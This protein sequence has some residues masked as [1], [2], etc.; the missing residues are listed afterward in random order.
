[1]Q[2]GVLNR[3][4]A[5]RFPEAESGYNHALTLDIEPFDT[6]L[7]YRSRS[8]GSSWFQSS[9][10]MVDGRVWTTKALPAHD[11]RYA[12]FTGQ[13]RPLTLG[14]VVRSTSVVTPNYY[15]DSANVDR[16]R[17]LKSA[18]REAR[19]SLTGFEYQYTEGAMA[20]P[21]PLDRPGRTILTSE[22]GTT[23]SRTK[24]VVMDGTGKLR[25]LTPEELEA[26]QGFPRGHTDHPEASPAQRGFLM[27]NALVTGLV[28][29][30]G[31]ALHEAHVRS[32]SESGA[33]VRPPH[34]GVEAKNDPVTSVAAA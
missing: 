31:E 11:I 24:H 26:L 13:D 23:P 6:Q 7:R 10:V 19:T 1:M 12:D 16:W 4:F 8:D 32:M 2:A 25:R 34:Y 9:S 14:D 29:R 17:Y 20:F 18:K 33:P 30:I 3:A 15:I 28:R 21:D 5:A 27:G 22:G